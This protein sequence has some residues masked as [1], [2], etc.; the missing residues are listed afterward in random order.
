[1]QVGDQ[2]HQDLLIDFDRKEKDG[3]SMGRVWKERGPL[4]CQ[5]RWWC[6]LLTW[7]RWRRLGVAKDHLFA[8]G[9]GGEQFFWS[10]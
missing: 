5:S 6:H 4:S 8:G 1:M 2:N 3:G 7:G 9:G 10:C